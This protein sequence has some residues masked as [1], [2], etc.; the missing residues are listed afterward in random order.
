MFV[1]LLTLLLSAAPAVKLTPPAAQPNGAWSRTLT[2][3]DKAGEHQVRFELGAQKQKAVGDD[4]IERTQLLTVVH[5]LGK[6]EL[7]RAKDFVEK[8]EFDLALELVEGSIEVTDLDDDGEAEISFLYRLG[9][10]SDVSPLSAK[11]LMYEGTTKYALRGDTRE[12]VSEKDFMG[13]SFTVDP[14]FEKAP[15]K[16]LTFAKQQWKAL[17]VDRVEAQA[18]P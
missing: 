6:K 1:R 7:W 11:L 4:F 9:C 13:G 14:A 12:R 16:F 15:A 3:T 5:T 2:F 10:R 18:A 8:C 17:I